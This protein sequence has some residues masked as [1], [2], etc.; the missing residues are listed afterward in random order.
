MILDYLFITGQA[1]SAMLLLYGAFLV[2]MPARKRTEQVA[3][4]QDE[5]LLAKY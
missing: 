2:L 4:P 3:V 1:A 5:M